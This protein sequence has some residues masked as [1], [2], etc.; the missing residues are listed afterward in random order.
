[1]N[2]SLS[3]FRSKLV[4]LWI[5]YSFKLSKILF[6]LLSDEYLARAIAL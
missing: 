6:P 5:I 2:N 4:F 3:L 1:M